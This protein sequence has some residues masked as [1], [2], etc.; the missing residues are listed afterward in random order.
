M[1]LAEFKLRVINGL[2]GWVD[3]YFGSSAMNERFINSTLKLLIKQNANKFDKYIYMFADENGEINAREVVESY[4]GMLGDDG[5]TF[6]LKQYITNDT[7][8]DFIPNKVLIIKKDDLMALV[9]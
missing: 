3:D 2:N 7:I 6:D 1:K 9:K 8:R 5:W 4:A